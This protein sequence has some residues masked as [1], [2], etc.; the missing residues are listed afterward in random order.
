[1]AHAWFATP[2][3]ESGAVERVFGGGKST[4]AA[5]ALAARDALLREVAPANEK[6]AVDVTAGQVARAIENT[7][8]V[9]RSKAMIDAALVIKHHVANMREAQRREWSGERE[10]T[11]RL[12]NKLARRIE[13]TP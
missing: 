6:Y 8:L 1:M 12:L 4:L 5:D 11:M 3:G 7:R 9:A 2:M 10:R 13:G